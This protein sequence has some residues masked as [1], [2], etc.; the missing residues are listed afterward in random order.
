MTHRMKSKWKKKLVP[1]CEECDEELDGNGSI[2]SPYSCPAGEWKYD[3]EANCYKL[4][5]KTDE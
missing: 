5:P 2:V 1:F 3:L 4:T